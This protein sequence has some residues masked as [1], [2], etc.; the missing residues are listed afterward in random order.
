M[1]SGELVPYA[2]KVVCG[3]AAAFM[4]ILA[5]SKT[6]EVS[7]TCA[8]A[9]VVVRFAGEM[10]DMLCALHLLAAP[11]LSLFGLQA[12]ELFFTVVPALLLI[13]AFAAVMYNA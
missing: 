2:L 1:M 5:W 3:F 8:A 9:A 11:E 10:F 7:W 6:R 4:A 12:T 13:I